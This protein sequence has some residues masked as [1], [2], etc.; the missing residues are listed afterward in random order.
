LRILRWDEPPLT[1]ADHVPTG[2]IDDI[3][4]AAQLY[5]NYNAFVATEGAFYQTTDG[6]LYVEVRQTGGC[7]TVTVSPRAPVAVTSP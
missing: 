3:V 7:C 6:V 2:E 1:G 4:N 5:I